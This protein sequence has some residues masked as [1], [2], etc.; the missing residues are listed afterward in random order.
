M[1]EALRGHR[2]IL[3]DSCIWIYHLER[4]PDYVDLTRMLLQQ[5]ATGDCHGIGSELTLLEIQMTSIRQGRDEIAGEDE[6]LLDNFPNLTLQPVDRN[7]LRRA[8][9][10]RARYK[11][12]T[13]DAIIL[14][15]GLE[16]GASLAM[17]NDKQW[18]RVKGIEVVCMADYDS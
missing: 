18:R 6:I 16:F 14:A 4:N 13:P 12:K 15:T 1:I 7:V 8:V 2:R 3:L 9:R 17:T 5:V 10:L 11:L